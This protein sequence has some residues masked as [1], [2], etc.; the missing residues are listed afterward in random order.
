MKLL[1]SRLSNFECRSLSKFFKAITGEVTKKV[2]LSYARTASEIRF[3]DNVILRIELSNIPTVITYLY[4]FL[5]FYVRFTIVLT[6]CNCKPV[7]L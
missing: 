6:K 5:C 4:F 3:Y 2:F 7:L 1:G